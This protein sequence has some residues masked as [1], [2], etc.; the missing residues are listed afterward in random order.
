MKVIEMT[1][2]CPRCKNRSLMIQQTLELPA[3][4]RSDEIALQILRCGS[5]GFGGLAVYEESRRGALDSE[6]FDHTGYELDHAVL[7]ELAAELGGCP[8]PGNSSCHCPA[9]QKF[10]SLDRNGRW[11]GLGGLPVGKVFPLIR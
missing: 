11:A 5:C 8:E 7:E 10:A 1:L 4:S 3:D 9:H 2:L 6:S